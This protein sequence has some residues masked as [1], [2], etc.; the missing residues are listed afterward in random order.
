MQNLG[1]DLSV[2]LAEETVE[3]RL[4]QPQKERVESLWQKALASSSALLF[5]GTIVAFDRLEASCL[6]VQ[7][8]EYKT[9]LAIRQDPQ[10]SKALRVYPLGVSALTICRDS[11]LMGLRSPRVAHRSGYYECAPAGCLDLHDLSGDTLNPEE[12][13]FRELEEETGFCRSDIEASKLVSL[14]F[15]S[16]GGIYDLC[17]ELRLYSSIYTRPLKLTEEYAPLFWLKSSEWGSF[18]ERERTKLIPTTVA[19]IRSAIAQFDRAK[20]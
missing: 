11:I 20:K 15:D 12:L 8:M 19:L 13:I 7:R 1:P 9:L 17:Y 3:M 5:N 2:R 18:L 14:V 4:S 16:E 10:L 6:F